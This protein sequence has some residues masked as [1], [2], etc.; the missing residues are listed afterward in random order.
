[1]LKLGN[2]VWGPLATQ[3]FHMKFP[4]WPQLTRTGSNGPVRAT[5]NSQAAISFIFH[6]RISLFSLPSVSLWQ[7]L[8]QTRGQ[9]SIQPNYTSNTAKISG[10]GNSWNLTQK[11][12]SSVSG[13]HKS[14]FCLILRLLNQR[15]WKLSNSN[16]ACIFQNF[17]NYPLFWVRLIGVKIPEPFLGSMVSGL[18]EDTN[19][20]EASSTVLV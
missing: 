11:C 18:L 3:T 9:F 13:S 15:F 16:E 20:V 8:L 2:G 1:M 4:C 7:F 17:G 14:S 6:L 19:Y 12:P 10:Q 5:Y